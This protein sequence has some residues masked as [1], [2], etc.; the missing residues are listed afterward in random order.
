MR[1][2]LSGLVT[3]IIVAIVSAG[4]VQLEAGVISGLEGVYGPAG[5]YGGFIVGSDYPNNDNPGGVSPNML[6]SSGTLTVLGLSPIDFVI[7]VTNSGG[8]TEYYVDFGTALNSTGADWVGYEFS[9]GVGHGAN[10]QRLSEFSSYAIPGLDSDF[11]DQDLTPNTDVFD[12]K[13]WEPDRIVFCGGGIVPAG[14]SGVASDF[15]LDV[16][17]FGTASS[18]LFTIRGNPIVPEPS[19]V[20]IWSLLGLCSI[21]VSWYRRRK[22]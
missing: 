20:V 11:P 5:G 4:T 12:L 19:T 3:L 6:V 2:I 9:L 16:P 7:E 14:G 8:T 21:G 17:D 15:S 1:S 13:S 18:Y 10:F 22:A